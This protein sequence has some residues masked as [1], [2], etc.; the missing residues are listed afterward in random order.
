LI[1]GEPPPLVPKGSVAP[2]T[3]LED[4]P[5]AGS[6]KGGVGDLPHGS[7]STER[8]PAHSCE[9]YAPSFVGF[10]LPGHGDPYVDCG[11]TMARGCENTHL[12]PQGLDGRPRGAVFVQLY[13]RTCLRAQCP[14]CYESWC[15]KHAKRIDHRLR[16]YKPPKFRRPIHV[17]VSPPMSDWGLDYGSL[18]RK[19]Y[20]IVRSV[21]VSGGCCIPHPFRINEVEGRVVSP[22]FHILGYGWTV[23][24][25]VSEAYAKS[26]WVVKNLGV[27]NSVNATAHY[28]LSHAGVKFGRHTITWFGNLS[29][30]VLYVAPYVEESPRCPMCKAILKPLPLSLVAGLDPPPLGDYWYTSECG[31]RKWIVEEP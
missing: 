2:R 26:G 11:S 12:H 1:T 23:G 3:K 21:G 25:V 19:A 31:L 17:V 16:S 4:S 24:K 5:I 6:L 27:R 29:Y 10:E 9:N 14:V 20:K 15:A 18:R 8:N 7:T 22:H 28:L 30:N 13:R